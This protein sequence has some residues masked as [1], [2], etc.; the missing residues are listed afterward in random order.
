MTDFEKKLPLYHTAYS[1]EF[2]SFVGIVN[3][4]FN[5]DWQEWCIQ[6]RLAGKAISG[7]LYSFLPSDLT[8]YCL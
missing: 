3:V 5:E 4:F 2:E 6:A 7:E 8:D 1:P